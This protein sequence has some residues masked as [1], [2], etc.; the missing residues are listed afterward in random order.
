MDYVS[1]SEVAR[2]FVAN[3]AAKSRFSIA[4]AVDA[5]CGTSEDSS[6]SVVPLFRL[7][8][9]ARTGRSRILIHVASF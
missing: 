5:Q 2:C 6:A 4:H 1:P 8:A 3:G 9:G 7:V